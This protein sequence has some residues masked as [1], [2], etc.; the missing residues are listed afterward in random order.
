MQIHR[1]LQSHSSAPCTPQ[2]N[3]KLNSIFYRNDLSRNAL[4]NAVQ[5]VL[6]LYTR[7]KAEQCEPPPLRYNGNK[8]RCYALISFPYQ[9]TFTLQHWCSVS[10]FAVSIL[11]TNIGCMIII[12]LEN[13]DFTWVRGEW[14]KI[15]STNNAISLRVKQSYVENLI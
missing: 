14:I 10:R 2:I 12:R 8:P 4:E 15:S 5:G 11:L 1:L 7:V 9:I 6:L 3:T 13:F